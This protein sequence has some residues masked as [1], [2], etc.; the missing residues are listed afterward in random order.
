LD[1]PQKTES[2]TFVRNLKNVSATDVAQLLSQIYGNRQGVN[3]NNPFGNTS[4]G[5]N[6]AS[7]FNTNRNNNTSPF[8][9]NGRSGG[10][11]GFGGG[12]F[13]G[14]GFGGGGFGG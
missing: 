3:S 11:G 2:T 5:R 1:K 4:T 7:R 14:G 12:G 9:N 8:G 13:G 6:G 10:G